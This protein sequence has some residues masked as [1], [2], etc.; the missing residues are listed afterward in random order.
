MI[1]VDKMDIAALIAESLDSH[2][3]FTDEERKFLHSATESIDI[4]HLSIAGKLLKIFDDTSSLIG[5]GILL[6][7]IFGGAAGVIGYF[8]LK[9]FK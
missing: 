3:S 2:C 4:K 1:D 6:A 7:L 9:L 8:A 5:K